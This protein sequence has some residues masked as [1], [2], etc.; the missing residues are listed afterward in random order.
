MPAK[1][2][3]MVIIVKREAWN[4]SDYL[5]K[6][7][8]VRNSFKIASP[9]LCPEAALPIVLLTWHLSAVGPPQPAEQW[10]LQHWPLPDSSMK[11]RSSPHPIHW[12]FT[13]VTAREEIQYSELPLI[14][15]P[16]MRP[17]LYSGHFKM[18]QSM[19]PSG[20]LPLKWGH[21]SNQQVPR[22]A[23]LEGVH[24]RWY[25][26]TSLLWSHVY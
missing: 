15:T 24:C 1:I 17:P 12:R 2:G 3:A 8:S 13:F 11:H 6:R 20:N 22:V 10:G 16:E 4:C 14:W 9:S 19:L 7:F 21:P 26:A 23:G 18:S 5:A 25:S